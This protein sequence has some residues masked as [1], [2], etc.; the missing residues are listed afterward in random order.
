MKQMKKLVAILLAISLCLPF[1]IIT[2]A[3][4][5]E[6]T[7]AQYSLCKGNSMTIK[8]TGLKGKIKWSSS[9]KSCVSV[10]SAGKVKAK[11]AGTAI[12]S[13]KSGKNAYK[14]L[15]TVQKSSL[16][17]T[18]KTIEKNQYYQLAVRNNKDSVKWTSKNKN[19][20]R[21]SSTG[22]IVGVKAGK[23]TIT[24]KIKQGTLTC[25]VVVKASVHKHNFVKSTKQKATCDKEGIFEYKCS[26]CA[27]KY[28]QYTDALGHNFKKTVVKPTCMQKGYTQYVCTYNKAHTYKSDYVNATGHTWDKGRIIKEATSK[29]NGEKK[30]T[31]K[32]CGTEKTEVVPKDESVKRIVTD[33]KIYVEG[34]DIKVTAQGD[35]DA[36]VGIYTETDDVDSVSPIYR[37]N[38]VDAK[39]ESGKTY[40]I[41]E[42][43][44]KGRNDLSTLPEGK[45]KLLL[46]KNAG[47][48]VDDYCYITI[49]DNGKAKLQ[50]DKAVYGP[51]TRVMVTAKGSGSDWVGIYA[52]NDLP[53]ENASGGVKSIYWYYVAKD[54]HSSGKAYAINKI[55]YYNAERSQYKDLPAGKYKALLFKDG[56][57]EASEQFDFTIEGDDQPVAP[58][59]VSY[60]LDNDYDGLANGKITVELSDT[61]NTSSD[62]VMYWA[63]DQG[64]L[65]EYTSLAKFKVAG[66]TTEFNMYE[67]TII[68]A[69]ATR[70]LVYT[71]N[72]FGTSKQYAEVK[73]PEG[74]NFKVDN[75]TPITEFE[76]VSD[77]HITDRT[78]N[79]GDTNYKNNQH[80][81]QML[82]DVKKN[83]PGSKAIIIN[84]D[85]ADTGK[86]SEYKNMKQI[87]SEVSSEVSGLPEIYMSVGNH[88]LS[89]ND[90]KT[91]AD[92]FIKY[93]ETGTDKVYY[94]RTINGYHYIFLGS[95]KQGLRADLS[96]AQL[97][98]FDNLLAKD[99]KENPEKPVFVMLHQ[100][101]YNTVAGSLPG[102][103][104]DGA[105]SE[106]TAQAKQLRAILKKYPQVLMFNGHSHWELNSEKSMYVRDEELPNI[107]NTASVGYLWTSYEVDTGEYMQGSHGYVIRVYKDKVMVMG[108][109]F[110]NEKYVPSAVFVAENYTK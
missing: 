86:E 42:E 62:I 79:E 96:E 37:Y 63:D 24:A 25:K 68:P 21:V 41:Q 78:M 70:L 7:N 47:Y 20:A 87:Y 52:K 59:R 22:M 13:A 57:Y 109:D 85:I 11:K 49:K 23:T 17:K 94:D 110:E 67:N 35:D 3:A 33:K 108:R 100:S 44:F 95:E 83:S 88:D 74:C 71:T 97:K 69:G 9:N 103:N 1:N 92:L 45:Y 12:V 4:K 19:I 58:E 102:Q 8:K 56:S 27:K 10:T 76:M 105:G 6:Q 48:D 106:G 36:W 107:F 77:I 46:F 98:W 34:E 14:V 99:T 93:A 55:G 32:V 5:K 81:K 82:E 29:E 61:D 91:Q 38:V 80:F 89:A 75:E 60:V 43:S 104:W 28:K 66:K 16:N 65:S 73:L 40:T 72:T 84:G 101:L 90:Y 30:F 31:C 50:L 53:D 26:S 2:Q 18:T 51:G 54:G 64:P 39:H 15:V